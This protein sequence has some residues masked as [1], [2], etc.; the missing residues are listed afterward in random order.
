MKSRNIFSRLKRAKTS[1]EKGETDN[2]VA[3]I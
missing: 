3:L 1:N 2:C